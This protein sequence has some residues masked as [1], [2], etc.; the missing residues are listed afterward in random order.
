[1]TTDTSTPAGIELANYPSP[2]TS[3]RG[4]PDLGLSAGELEDQKNRRIAHSYPFAL[5]HHRPASV[6]LGAL[7]DDE[8]DERDP[9]LLKSRLQDEKATKSSKMSKKLRDFYANQN[10]R[11]AS[12]LKPLVSHAQESADA[13]RANR[14]PVKI[15]IWASLAA[16]VT[17]AVLQIYAA[18]ASL[19]LSFFA[20]AIDAIFDPVVTILLWYLNRKAAR[21]DPIKWP[22]GGQRLVNVGSCLYSMVMAGASVVLIVESIRDL[23]SHSGNETEKFHLPSTIIVGI[24]VVTKFCLFL[25]CYQTRH[26]GPACRVLYEDHR[27]DLMLNSFALVTNALG[28]K[29]A[30]WIDPAGAIVLSLV[31][32]YLWGSSALMELNCLAGIG[33][34]KDI[35]ELIIYKAM[36]FSDKVTKVDSCKI[37]HSGTNYVVELDVVMPPETPLHIAHDIS[38]ILQDQLETLP[39]VDRCY[40]HIDHETSHSPEHRKYV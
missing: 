20:S 30:W 22:A 17:L 36:T 39:S 23:A 14:M 13:E 3:R 27:N 21:V 10:E 2:P 28:A 38:Q 16:N 31:L 35:Q 37:F 25:Y 40:V 6:A 8:E 15:A 7:G 32:I 11:I 19:S 1:M 18:V 29:I 4:S 33:A 12:L 24:A 34:P 26:M 9:L 5:M